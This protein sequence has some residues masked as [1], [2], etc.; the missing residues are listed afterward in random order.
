MGS[1]SVGVAHCCFGNHRLTAASAAVE[2]AQQ[3]EKRYGEARKYGER[4]AANG[5]V[6]GSSVKKNETK[7]T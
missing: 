5:S 3:K 4:R 2:T 7:K 1:D 6:V